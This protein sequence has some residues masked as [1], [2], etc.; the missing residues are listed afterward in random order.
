MTTNENEPGDNTE[1]EEGG[2]STGRSGGS[3]GEV[4]FHFETFV[5]KRDDL[6]SFEE[7]KRLRL[8]EKGL[9][10]EITNKQK[11]IIKERDAAKKGIKPHQNNVNANQFGGNDFGSNFKTHPISNTAQ[12]S[13]AEKQVVGVPNLGKIQTNERDQKKLVDEFTHQLTLKNKNTKE[14]GHEYV[15]TSRPRPKPTPFG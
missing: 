11:L 9:H 4:L 1:D 2:T 5:E 7:I 8:V 13:G 14:M 12:F 15:P 3:S 10:K 6:L